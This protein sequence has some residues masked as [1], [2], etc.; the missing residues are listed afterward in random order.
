MEWTR[1][2]VQS[3]DDSIEDSSDFEDLKIGLDTNAESMHESFLKSMPH[4]SEVQERHI[5]VVSEIESRALSS[6]VSSLGDFLSEFG[7]EWSE[8]EIRVPLEAEIRE[9]VVVDSK[10]EDGGQLV[11]IISPERFGGLLRSF[12]LPEGRRIVGASWEGEILSIK[13]D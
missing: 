2:N 5:L 12:R 6:T 13:V 11:R 1:V 8:S 7:G 4:L 3:D 10:D 9:G